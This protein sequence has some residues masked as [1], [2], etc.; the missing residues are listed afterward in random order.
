M[1]KPPGLSEATTHAL[2]G[3]PMTMSTLMELALNDPHCQNNK[4]NDGRRGGSK[5]K[6]AAKGKSNISERKEPDNKAKASQKERMPD[7]N[8]DN[9]QKASQGKPPYISDTK[10]KEIYK[11]SMVLVLPSLQSPVIYDRDD[12]LIATLELVG[13]AFYLDVKGVDLRK[14]LDR[15]TPIYAG[16]TAIKWRPLNTIAT[17]ITLPIREVPQHAKTGSEEYDILLKE[18]H[19]WHCRLGHQGIKL[20][21]KTAHITEGM[22]SLDRLKDGDFFCEIC[23][24]TNSKRRPSTGTISHPARLKASVFSS[25]KSARPLIAHTAAAFFLYYGTPAAKMQFAAESGQPDGGTLSSLTDYDW[26]KKVNC[27][28]MHPSSAI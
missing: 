26:I 15:I 23:A 10:L 8:S 2:R 19:L 21:K 9:K 17:T 1:E 4:P 12:D 14:Q 6:G 13:N 24:I 22:P 28:R 18:V 5:G 3:P 7:Q 16:M 20:L 25:D 11:K 27:P